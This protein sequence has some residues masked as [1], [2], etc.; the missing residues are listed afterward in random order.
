MSTDQYWHQILT[1]RTAEHVTAR[2]VVFLVSLIVFLARTLFVLKGFYIIVYALGIVLLSQVN[3]YW[4]P[5]NDLLSSTTT[6]TTTA[7]VENDRQRRLSEFQ[8]WFISIRAVILSAIL[9]CFAVFDVPVYW[10]ILLL[11]FVFLVV[12]LTAQTLRRR[13]SVVAATKT[14]AEALDSNRKGGNSGNTTVKISLVPR[15]DH[16][17][18]HYAIKSIEPWS[19][20]KVPPTFWKDINPTE[21]VDFLRDVEGA[22]TSKDK[23]AATNSVGIF[24]ALFFLS[25]VAF[26]K[27]FESSFLRAYFVH[28]YQRRVLWLALLA[29][30]PVTLFAIISVR[31][32]LKWQS[33][34]LS[35]MTDK[36]QHICDDFEVRH[37]HI[38]CNVK[39]LRIQVLVEVSAI[40]TS[41]A[42]QI[43]VPNQ[44]TSS[45]TDPLLQNVA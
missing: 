4:S 12:F 32:L 22:T 11:Y 19:A 42:N 36:I 16:L 24:V 18:V 30:G 38:S 7:A 8:V 29:F 26:Q 1:E 33:N 35:T 28:D 37:P 43:S 10:P 23:N 17:F 13:R 39:K 5:L 9:T 41:G 27:M 45:S 21:W 3:S 40:Q 44:E 15:S 20:V 2:W 34:E 6:T 31:S 25:N 14:E